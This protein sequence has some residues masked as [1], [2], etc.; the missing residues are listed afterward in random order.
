MTIKITNPG[1]TIE[2]LSDLDINVIQVAL[3]HLIEDL[4]HNDDQD[5]DAQLVSAKKIYLSLGGKA[6]WES[7]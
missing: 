4:I 2:G 3:T 7:G 6:F 5:L 1:Q